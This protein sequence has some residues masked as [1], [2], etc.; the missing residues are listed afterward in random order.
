M[1]TTDPNVKVTGEVAAE[2]EPQQQAPVS[3]GNGIG[4]QEAT[5]V[6]QQP[7]APVLPRYHHHN[8]TNLW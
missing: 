6:Q 2:P 7:P 3:N 1:N 8:S 5:P 4:G